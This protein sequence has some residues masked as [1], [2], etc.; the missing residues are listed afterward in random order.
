METGEMSAHPAHHMEFEAGAAAPDCQRNANK[1]LAHAAVDNCCPP[2]CFAD[3]A[4]LHQPDVRGWN[5]S[6]FYSMAADALLSAATVRL[7]HPP[8]H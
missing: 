1:S 2:S 4:M 7:E 3:L 5:V 8:E 6:P